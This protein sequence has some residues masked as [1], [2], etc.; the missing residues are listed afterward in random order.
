MPRAVV[1]PSE[2]QADRDADEALRHAIRWGVP[3]DRRFDHDAV[4]AALDVVNGDLVRVDMNTG[5][6]TTVTHV[7]A[8]DVQCGPGVRLSSEVLFPCRTGHDLPT[9][10]DVYGQRD[11]GIIIFSYAVD[12]RTTLMDNGPGPMLKPFSIGDDGGMTLNF[13]AGICKPKHEGRPVLHA[14][15]SGHRHLIEAA[16]RGG[17][18]RFQPVRWVPRADGAVALVVNGVD[19][20]PEAWGLVDGTPPALH[21][22]AA[23]PLDVRAALLRGRLWSVCPIP[24]VDSWVDRD[25]SLTAAGSLLGWVRAGDRLGRVEILPDGTVYRAPERFERIV[26]AG[27]VALARAVD[28]RVFETVDHGVTWKE[29]PASPGE[30]P[31]AEPLSCVPRPLIFS[32]PPGPIC[33]V[34]GK[35]CLGPGDPAGP[36]PPPSHPVCSLLGCDFGSWLRVGWSPNIQ[37]GGARVSMLLQRPQ[38]SVPWTPW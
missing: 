17:P 19:G 26:S 5:A 15:G 1:M 21:R 2:K 28:G 18:L 23:T 20:D 29:V 11:L 8:A 35:W 16:G 36:P 4:P 10:A 38:K 6:V 9:A 37:I 13:G 22:W 7:P 32:E 31:G 25:W 30:L 12:G 27:P 14:D 24:D 33:D 3:A 34:S